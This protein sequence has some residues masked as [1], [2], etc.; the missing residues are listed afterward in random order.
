VSDPLDRLARQVAAAYGPAVAGADWAALGSAGGFSG[1]RVWRGVAADGRAFCL[2]A[3]GPA[4]DREWLEHGIHH[5]MRRARA[6][7]FEFVPQVE[8]TRSDR[9]VVAAGGR[10]WEVTTWM[11]GKAD[12]CR[13]P[14]DGRLFAAVRAVA[15]IHGA[16]A[17][18]GTLGS[19]P[20]VVRRWK[21]LR[22]W[23]ELVRGGWRPRFEADDPVRP[24]AEA[25]WGLLPPVLADVWP[26]ILYW[27]HEKVRSQ[28]CLC[29]VWHDHVL[30]DGDRVTGVI[31]YAAA[32]FDHVAVD[33]AR[34][35]GS[36]VPDDPARTEAALR[37]YE[38]ILPL[39]EPELVALLDRAGVVVGVTNW[40]RWLYH[41]GRP[42][43]DRRA[44]AARLEGLVGRLE[45]LSG[46][47]GGYLF[48]G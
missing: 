17:A 4:A 39:P 44:V 34:L 8:R 1:A 40:L 32:K 9:T 25:A 24:H 7:G 26:A 36:L 14:S 45:R 12:F 13:D 29:D 38:A 23:E 27:L 47:R 31:D 41:D 46:L 21:A 37:A 30:F 16:W 33:L 10:V 2:K 35:L 3:H 15:H 19:C 20:A 28:P 5:W 22:A 18:A 11:P 43:P 6:A 48:G 42:F